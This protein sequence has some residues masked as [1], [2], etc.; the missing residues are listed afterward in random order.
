MPRPRKNQLSHRDRIVR[1]LTEEIVAGHWA[2]GDKLP[3][4]ET[5]AARF[6]TSQFPVV[7]AVKILSEN[8]YVATRK[9]S[10]MFVRD[11][12]SDL[13][14]HDS[15]ML[16]M[17]PTGH[18]FAQLTGLLCRRLHDLGLFASVLDITHGDKCELLRQALYSEARF[19]IGNF[20]AST[21]FS[22]LEP[23]ALARKHVIAAVAWEAPW[24]DAPVHRLLVDHSAGM[25]QVVQHLWEAGHRRILLAGTPNML[26]NAANWDGQGDCPPHLNVQGTG[27]AGCWSRRGGRVTAFVCHHERAHGPACDEKALLALLDGP[28]A[29][30]AVVGLR[31]VDA[32]DV[33]AVLQRHQRAL[34][35][36]LTF[37]GDGDTPWSQMAQ[38]PFSSQNWNLEQIADLAVGIIRDVE[39]G[40]VF[41]KPVFHLVAPRLVVR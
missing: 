29:P 12:P 5:L 14:M 1:A 16:C 28:E 10:G 36:R 7:Q 40:K 33:Q 18:V 2:V 21:P 39:A 3:S 6:K 17:S 23:E 11:R 15:V 19:I 4:L 37:F 25:R 41:K 30:T 38:P 8:G 22:V 13:K 31:D 20:G 24:S 32:W 27:L 35:Q 34:L 9:G 26:E